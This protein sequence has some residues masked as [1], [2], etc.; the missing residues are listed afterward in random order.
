MIFLTEPAICRAVAFEAGF[1]RLHLF[2]RLARA[3]PHSEQL[4]VIVTLR[5]R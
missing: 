4:C 1:E 2:T 5:E 3:A